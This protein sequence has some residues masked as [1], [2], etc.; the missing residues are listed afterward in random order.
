MIDMRTKLLLILTGLSLRASAPPAL[1]PLP[2]R[3]EFKTGGMP[4]DN[5][6]HVTSRGYT[7]ARLKAAAD[8]FTTR[9]SRQTGIPF[10][11]GSQR[12]TPVV[13]F[14]VEC[15]ASGPAYPTLGEDEAYQI[16]IAGAGARLR[17]ETSTGILRGFETLLQL[18]GPGEQGMSFPAVHIEDHP[19]FPWRGLMLDVS[20]HWMPLPVVL[21]NLDAMAAVKLNVFHWHLS[22]DQGFRVES[23][24]YPRLQQFGSDGNFYTQAEVRRAVDYAR[25]RG[26]RVI[27]EF[28]MP[29]HTTCWF[30]GY[31]ELASAPG[32][33]AIERTWGIFQPLVDP[34]KEQTYAFLDGLIGE[35]AGLFP[36]PDFHI[37]GD[38]VDDSQW[39]ASASIQTF[40][41]MHGMANSHEL[42]AYFNHRLQAIL[43][44]YGKTMIGWDE[45]LEPGLASSAIVQSWRGAESLS[46][47]ARQG[48]RTL[49][50]AGYYLD[51][52]KPASDH[53]AVDPLD[54]QAGQL[55]PA[56][57][58]RILGGEA[59]MWTEYTSP[60][61]L[62]S[63]LWPRVAA[64][65]ERFWS[66]RDVKDKES[67][68]SRLERVSRL[69]D[70]TGVTHR[71]NYG[72]MLDRLAGDRDSAPVRVLAD[73]VEALGI[74]GRRDERKYSSPVPLN[75]L[76]D[77]A[78]PESEMVRKLSQSVKAWLATRRP[79]DAGRILRQFTAW[80]ANPTELRSL[81]PENYLIG[82]L[83]PLSENLAGTGAIG[84]EALSYLQ[85]GQAPP[86][87]WIASRN[88]ELDQ[89]AKP[90]AETRLAS[91][92]PVRLL[93]N[94]LAQPGTNE[95]NH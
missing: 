41:N 60:E 16:D 54:G 79:E 95:V 34:S 45:V 39:K 19:R 42:H 50:S 29:G 72:P 70:F 74:E 47:A 9:L 27:P 61:S 53:Y 68:Y 30:A 21:R 1:M 51:Y 4:I 88:R 36:D 20:R 18:A 8:R 85:N 3:L 64:I 73:S 84:A 59:C 2:Y 17:A 90:R 46:E 81:A 67:M 40:E 78:S 25:D 87:G 31:P 55:T 83:L 65:A 58:A 80:S 62:D 15:R 48:H 49:L 57:T 82:E 76:V 12:A 32:P 13:E 93:V 63:R 7:D 35:M 56:E 92:D 10:Y 77:A 6:F 75:R 44:K 26:I 86:D 91:V 89:Y 43:T 11:A 71:T 14:V 5:S 69:L 38:E 37:G 24:R 22:D 66:P 23:K 28:D 94:A 33:Y 52:L